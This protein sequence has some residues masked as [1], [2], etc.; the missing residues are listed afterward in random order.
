[1]PTHWTDK[2]AAKALLGKALEAEGFK[3]YGW[4]EDRSD[5]MTDLYD[6]ENWDGIAEHRSGAL[7]LVDA[8]PYLVESTSG[9]VK[10]VRGIAGG[11]CPRCEGSGAEPGSP[12]TL[13]TAREDPVTFNTA[14]AAKRGAVHLTPHVVSP[15]HFLEDG[16]GR[17]KCDSCHGGAKRVTSEEYIDP[18]PVFQATPKGA[19]WHVERGGRIIAKGTGVWSLSE[20][21]P[22]LEPGKSRQAGKLALL[23][24]RILEA[25]EGREK[26]DEA[27]PGQV[28]GEGVTK[29]P[30]TRP[31]FVELRFAVKPPA[32]IRAELKAAGFRW[33]RRSACWYGPGARLPGRWAPDH[34]PAIDLTGHAPD[35]DQVLDDAAT[36]VDRE[37]GS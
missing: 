18:C 9:G 14:R 36:P 24:G 10:K 22:H 1:M 6:P 26:A 29:R 33:A 13:A 19:T 28:A 11:P 21:N 16:T 27:T 25:V 8:S 2:R 37:L 31:G 32:E 12:W 35:L 30:G 4:K 34:V 23:V 20:P 15:L 7:V 17:E 5:S 3:L